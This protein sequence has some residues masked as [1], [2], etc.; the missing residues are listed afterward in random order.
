MNITTVLSLFSFYKSLTMKRSSL[1]ILLVT[2]YA[3]ANAQHSSIIQLDQKNIQAKEYAEMPVDLCLF[4]YDSDKLKKAGFE[5]SIP[6]I[7]NATDTALAFLMVDPSATDFSKKYKAITILNYKSTTPILIHAAHKKDAPPTVDNQKFDTPYIIQTENEGE[8]RYQLSKQTHGAREGAIVFPKTGLDTI[9]SEYWPLQTPLFIKAGAFKV[10]KTT[11]TIG[12]IDANQNGRYDDYET[13]FVFISKIKPTVIP[14]LQSSSCTPIKKGVTISIENELYT[15]TAVDKKGNALALD[16]STNKGEGDVHFLTKLP[17]FNY[18][19][20]FGVSKELNSN[21]EKGKVLYLFFWNTHCTGCVDYV[22]LLKNIYSEHKDKMNVLG[23]N[24]ED[25]P[26]NIATFTEKNK[27]QWE[28]GFVTSELSIQLGQDKM[29]FGVL[30]KDDGT[31]IKTSINLTE[32][33][34]Y[35]SN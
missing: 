20:T 27:I 16:K 29:P 34:K 12:L 1:F 2:C 24:W 9:S 4:K 3:I 22:E 26:K 11:V 5:I 30:V 6:Y 18:E 13:D 28:Q 31:I 7:K 19:N 23:L 15:L 35:L 21:L 33:K 25:A 32:L 14:T 8:I 17:K 10:N